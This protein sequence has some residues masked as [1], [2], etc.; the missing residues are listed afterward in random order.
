MPENSR[1]ARHGPGVELEGGPPPALSGKTVLVTGTGDVLARM[2]AAEAARRGAVTATP[3]EIAADDADCDRIVDAFITRFGHIDA[4]IATIGAPRLGALADM[5][6]DVWQDSVIAPLRQAFWLARR[7]LWEFLA[8]GSGGRLVFVTEPPREWAA[9]ATGHEPN[10]VVGGALYSF[11]R[12]IAKEV[13]SRAVACN[14]VLAAPASP[15]GGRRSRGEPWA[16]SEDYFVQPLIE[17]ALYLASENASFVNGEAL[18]VCV[19]G[20]EPEAGAP[21][22]GSP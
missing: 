21:P 20:H 5:S 14:V 15:A 7:V 19:G 9:G 3:G 16:A 17:S 10:T 22:V 11:A 6:L 12:S 8:G 4:A 18:T 1:P 13:G 2:L